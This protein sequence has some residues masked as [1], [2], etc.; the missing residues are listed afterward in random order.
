[1]TNA[2]PQPLRNVRV[3]SL[4]LNLPGT[5]HQGGGAGQVERKAQ[6]TGVAQGLGQGGGHGW[7]GVSVLW[8]LNGGGDAG[9]SRYAPAHS[10]RYT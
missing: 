4:A 6:N 3:L 9:T 2:L 5:A 8:F 10:L 7:E 1:M